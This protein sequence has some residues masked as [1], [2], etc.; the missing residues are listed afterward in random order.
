MS[1]EKTW[2]ILRVMLN[3]RLSTPSLSCNLIPE[4]LHSMILHWHF[5]SDHLKCFSWLRGDY[6]LPRFLKLLVATKTNCNGS[7][8]H[9]FDLSISGSQQE[10]KISLLVSFMLC[11]VQTTPVHPDAR[12]RQKVMYDPHNKSLKYMEY[13]S[14]RVTVYQNFLQSNAENRMWFHFAQWARC[15]LRLCMCIRYSNPIDME[16]LQYLLWS[17]LKSL[18]VKFYM[19]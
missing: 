8:S 12:G 11:F 6:L 10:N 14:N 5:R 16:K 2:I 18:Q 1:Y 4:S 15:L 3:E 9:I 7:C 19:I 17:S 13:H